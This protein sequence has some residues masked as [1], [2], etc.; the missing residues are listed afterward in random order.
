MLGWFFFS[1]GVRYL[2]VLRSFAK[3][4]TLSVGFTDKLLLNQGVFRSKVPP[5]WTPQGTKHHLKFQKND[6]T[7]W[8]QRSEHCDLSRSVSL[9]HKMQKLK[10]QALPVP[11][12]EGVFLKNSFC[13]LLWP[14][15]N[16]HSFLRQQTLNNSGPQLVAFLNTKSTHFFQG[17]E[18]V[19]KQS[20]EELWSK[21]SSPIWRWV[22]LKNL[23]YPIQKGW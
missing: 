14:L 5:G 4:L 15:R 3:G 8:S 11:Y 6:R 7:S 19:K 21:L 18:E 13:F 2:A 23:G 10:C 17:E 20:R 9:V 22:K 16:F 12:K 1:P